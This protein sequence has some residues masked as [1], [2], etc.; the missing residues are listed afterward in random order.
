MSGILALSLMLAAGAAPAPPA[1]DE[2]V[3]IARKMRF[4][5]VDIKAPTRNGHLV[6]ER[7]RV[8][9]SSGD[10]ELDAVPC[11]VTQA[12]MTS[13]PKTRKD[14]RICVEQRSQLRINEIAARRRA[15][16]S[17]QS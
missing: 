5:K 17:G 15:A 10:A 6:L 9:R 11:E 13:N 7:C 8:S 2:I 12:C 4:I 3:V 14:L 1:E 16:R